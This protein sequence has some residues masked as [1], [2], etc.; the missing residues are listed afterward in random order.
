MRIRALVGVLVAAAVAAPALLAAPGAGLVGYGGEAGA[1]QGQLGA[2]A[3]GTLPF[4]GYDLGLFA[5]GAALLMAVGFV[6]RRAARA[7][8]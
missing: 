3:Q 7:S 5:L 1:I 2:T 4:T 8:N 6:V